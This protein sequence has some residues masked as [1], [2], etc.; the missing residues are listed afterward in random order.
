MRLRTTTAMRR[1]IEANSPA[2]LVL[3]HY[4][5]ANTDV[6]VMDQPNLFFWIAAAPALMKRF[7]WQPRRADVPLLCPSLFG[8]HPQ[9]VNPLSH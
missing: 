2:P 4:D 7:F 3:S 5:A 9:G 1:R 6:V 8:A